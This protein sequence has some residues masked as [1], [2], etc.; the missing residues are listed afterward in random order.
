M[1]AMKSSSPSRN[2]VVNTARRINTHRFCCCVCFS[3]SLDSGSVSYPVSGKWAAASDEG[4]DSVEADA[5]KMPARSKRRRSS[6]AVTPLRRSCLVM[7][8]PSIA[9]A[10]K[11]STN[12]LSFASKR[13]QCV[14]KMDA[15]RRQIK[16]QN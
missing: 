2:L 9:P 12:G 7:S 15:G 10:T 1:R 8:A 4:E 5:S 16:D 13:C 11:E 14:W 3:R 6:F